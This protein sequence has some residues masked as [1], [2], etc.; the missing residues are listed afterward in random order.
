[1]P[2]RLLSFSLR[3]QDNNALHRIDMKKT[4]LALTLLSLSGCSVYKVL[5]QDGPADLN[6]LGVGSTRQELM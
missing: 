4:L 5:S 6:G 3:K 1:M 2:K